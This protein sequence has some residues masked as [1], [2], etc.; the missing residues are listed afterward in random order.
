MPVFDRVSIDVHLVRAG[1][2]G[3]VDQQMQRAAAPHR[4]FNALLHR[5]RIA[6]VHP[7][8]HHPSTVGIEPRGGGGERRGVA[9]GHHHRG[10]APKQLGGDRFADAGG[11]ASHQRHPMFEILHSRSPAM[12]NSG[13]QASADR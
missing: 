12:L 8:R 5:R 9:A 13:E 1:D 7:Q 4:L 10:A 11:S 2:P 6:H 3:V